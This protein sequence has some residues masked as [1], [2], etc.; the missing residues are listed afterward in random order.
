[1][2]KVAIIGASGYTGVELL[3]LLA[4]HPEVEIT[5]ATSEQSTGKPVHQL[6]PHLGTLKHL[7]LEPFDVQVLSKKADLFFMALPHTT[8][9]S[10]V[11]ELL[12]GKKKVVDLSADF[13]FTNEEEFEKA[14]KV[15]H[16]HPQLLPSAVYGLPEL[17]RNSIQ[18]AT[19]VASPG[20]YP[21]GALLGLIPL[22]KEDLI[23]TDGIVINA[24]SGISGVGR[25]AKLDYHFP[26]VNESACAYGVVD[27]RHRPEINQELS[28]MAGESVVAAFTPHLIPMNRGILTTLYVRMKKPAGPLEWR[29][30]FATFYKHE[31]FI[32]ILP[33]GE[34]PNTR[35]VRGSNFCHIGVSPDPL[36]GQLIVVT[37][38][39]N[40]MKGASGQGI[41][42][43]NL[44]MGFD[45]TL[46]LDPIG[47][48]P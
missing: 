28:R 37:A 21:T 20:C 9:M 27:H 8:G 47:L 17:H 5:G 26:E 24:L 14:Y 45:E 4:R 7:I 42:S 35:Y 10:A 36:T 38:I 48:F 11:A 2:I 32:Q 1:M 44:M 19:L 33:Q 15:A 40:L 25:Q 41:Q 13:R 23:H 43:M 39:D 22:I 30:R 6:F 46:G 16:A 18:T 34:W 29:E 12:Q 31:P 3:R